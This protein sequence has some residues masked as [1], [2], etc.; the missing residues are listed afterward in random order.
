[1]RILLPP[2]EAKT[3]GGK[4]KPLGQRVRT[5]PLW[6]HRLILIRALE[7]LIGSNHAA[8]SLQLPN[9]VAAAALEANAKTLAS[10]TMPALDRYQGVVYSGL[11]VAAMSH[12][13][14]KVADR[15][16]LIFS[17]L[18]GVVT[19]GEAVPDY[20]VPAKV[21]LPGVGIAG[22]FWRQ[23]LTALLPPLLDDELIVDL[24]SS[25]YA[26]M[27]RPDRTD[28]VFDR[29][30]AVRI[31]SPK[32]DGTLG[33]ISFPS[34]YAKGKLAHGLLRRVVAGQPITSPEDVIE[35]W[36]DVGGKTG[37]VQRNRAGCIVELVTFTSTIG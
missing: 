27:W 15:V 2:S 1:V 5:N 26:A 24:R 17:G 4:G 21:S 34:K 6:S 9:S 32:P 14:R 19:G 35:A 16:L 29:V 12:A 18:F 30:L 23:Q 20:R 22:T 36:L 25:D 33:V 8:S 10:P 3:P 11:D 28:P 37:A 31:L 13:T 7:A